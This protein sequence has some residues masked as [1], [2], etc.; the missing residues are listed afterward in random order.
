[1]S[2]EGV[3][4]CCAGAAHAWHRRATAREQHHNH[5][6]ALDWCA[7]GLL[8]W[9]LTQHQVLTARLHFTSELDEAL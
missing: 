4:Y 1:M 6:F 3:G 2:I 8:W 9:L 5:E 7:D